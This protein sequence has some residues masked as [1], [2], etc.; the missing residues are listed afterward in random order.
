M[1]Q[2]RAYMIIDCLPVKVWSDKYQIGS[3]LTFP[4]LS[5]IKRSCLW[6]RLN[7]CGQDFCCW[8]K[9]WSLDNVNS[10]PTVTVKLLSIPRFIVT[11]K[12]FPIELAVITR[13]RIAG[14][15][16]TNRDFFWYNQYISV[17]HITKSIIRGDYYD[18]S[19]GWWLWCPLWG[20]NP[21]GAIN[22]YIILRAV[23]IYV[24]IYICLLGGLILR[25][26]DPDREWLWILVADIFV[27]FTSVLNINTG[28]DLGFSLSGLLRY[29]TNSIASWPVSTFT[30]TTLTDLLWLADRHQ[31]VSV[32]CE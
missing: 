4:Y 27:W 14:L 20:Q 17:Y 18:A 31:E 30:E 16:W 5:T 2:C 6:A 8:Q 12:S 24:Y 9:L 29:S 26:F 21:T 19:S 22:I 15:D 1:F 7:S 13:K 25:G 3:A 23:A 10:V 32:I 28:V 11:S